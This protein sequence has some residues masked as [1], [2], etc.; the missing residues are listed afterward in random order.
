MISVSQMRKELDHIYRYMG[1]C[2]EWSSY[3]NYFM[4]SRRKDVKNML[5]FDLCME[6]KDSM[7]RHLSNAERAYANDNI[8]EWQMK[9]FKYL[10]CTSFGEAFYGKRWRQLC[11]GE[12][13]NR[14]I[15]D[16]HM[17]QCEKWAMK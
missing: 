16:K 5:P 7:K 3:H 15:C 13:D 10:Q 2:W 9:R 17:E 11:G 8:S 12:H 14:R 1:I 6:Y 4:Q